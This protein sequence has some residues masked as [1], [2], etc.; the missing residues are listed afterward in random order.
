MLIIESS[1]ITKSIHREFKPLYV[2]GY[3]IIAHRNYIVGYWNKLLGKFNRS[4]TMINLNKW[5]LVEKVEE[6]DVIGFYNPAAKTL[7]PFNKN[8]LNVNSRE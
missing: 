1:K 6:I 5:K 3:Q 2:N 8:F 7:L 4:K